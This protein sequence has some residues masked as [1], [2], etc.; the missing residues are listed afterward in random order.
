MATRTNK[1]VRWIGTKPCMRLEIRRIISLMRLEEDNADVLKEAED[2]TDNDND[3]VYSTKPM[4]S[5]HIIPNFMEM[6]VMTFTGA[7]NISK[8]TECHH[9]SLK[10]RMITVN[11]GLQAA[12]FFS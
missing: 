7:H 10:M 5:L 9:T 12:P 2:K 4:V 1:G 3:M 11:S 8:E 6:C